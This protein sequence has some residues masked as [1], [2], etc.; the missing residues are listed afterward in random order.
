MRNRK[1]QREDFVSVQEDNMGD[2]DHYFESHALLLR[3]WSHKTRV[4]LLRSGR[5]MGEQVVSAIKR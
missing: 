2:K 3:V 1:Y 5:T 4:D